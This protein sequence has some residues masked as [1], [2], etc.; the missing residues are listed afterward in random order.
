MPKL[1]DAFREGPK[2]FITLRSFT[3]SLMVVRVLMLVIYLIYT[4]DTTENI[5]LTQFF[6]F[7]SIWFYNLSTFY[8]HYWSSSTHCEL[9]KL[10]LFHV[11]PSVKKCPWAR[12]TTEAKS[13]CTKFDVLRKQITTLRHNIIFI[14]QQSLVHQGLHIVEAS[15]TR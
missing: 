13:A 5:N 15:H 1:S 12:C 3:Q 4:L 6:I 11:S 10:P 14:A 8:V 2:L 9:S 7:M